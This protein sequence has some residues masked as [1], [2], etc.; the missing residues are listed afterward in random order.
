MSET[1][2][3]KQREPLPRGKNPEKKKRRRRS[4]SARSFDDKTRK[5]RSKNSGLRRFFHLSR[6]AENEKVIW[7]TF[8]IGILVTVGVIALWQFFIQERM[9]RQEESQNDYMEYQPAIPRLG[10]E[11]FITEGAPVQSSE[12]SSAPE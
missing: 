3:Y 5:R 7:T 1:D 2:I 10:E 6:K 8:G 12:E 11:S 4:T 9:I